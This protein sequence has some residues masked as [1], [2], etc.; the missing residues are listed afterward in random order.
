MTLK[1]YTQTKNIV[2]LF[3]TNKKIIELCLVV[4]KESVIKLRRISVK[5]D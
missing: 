4:K 5:K 3:K 2:T 1:E